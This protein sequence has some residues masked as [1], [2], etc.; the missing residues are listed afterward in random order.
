MLLQQRGEGELTYIE[1]GRNAGG[2]H[3]SKCRNKQGTTAVI[4]YQHS[5]ESSAERWIIMNSC[6]PLCGISECYWI[7][8][9]PSGSWLTKLETHSRPEARLPYCQVVGICGKAE[10]FHVFRHIQETC[11]QRLQILPKFTDLVN[12][13]TR[14]PNILVST[15]VSF[16]RITPS[17]QENYNKRIANEPSERLS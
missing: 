4:W 2:K 10:R 6:W 7:T 3:S 14:M 17:G 13:G 5:K 8:T 11:S 16:K 1:I 12:C 9:L 15:H